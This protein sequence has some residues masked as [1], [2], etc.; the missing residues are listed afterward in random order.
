MAP[1]PKAL[2]ELPEKV[3]LITV[4]VA[5]E[6]GPDVLKM[7]PPAAAELPLKVL[8]LTVSVP[9][10]VMAPPDPSLPG[11]GL[12]EK[13]QSLTVNVPRLVM[14]PLPMEPAPLAM[15]SPEMLAFVTA[16]LKEK[17]AT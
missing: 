16:L 11:A 3:L 8:L 5:V 4:V 7:A 17:T 13:V 12:L 15:V 2:A 14:A 6:E 10:L 9:M 1:P